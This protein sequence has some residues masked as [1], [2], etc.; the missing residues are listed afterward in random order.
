VDKVTDLLDP[1]VIEA[2]A[3]RMMA[4]NELY[5]LM[6]PSWQ[7]LTRNP[8]DPREAPVEVPVLMGALALPDSDDLMLIGP[9]EDEALFW[10]ETR[11]IIL[12]WRANQCEE[13]PDGTCD[14]PARLFGERGPRG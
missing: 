9:C 6:R 11:A 8:N 13:P 2:A 4:E 1:L 3:R 14:T 12:K 10:L 7:G 5:W